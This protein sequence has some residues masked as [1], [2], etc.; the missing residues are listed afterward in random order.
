MNVFFTPLSSY[1]FL[2][3]KLII[4]IVLKFQIAYVNSVSF[5]YSM[6]FSD[7]HKNKSRNYYILYMSQ[8]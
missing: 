3:M 8:G 5:S 4:L 6:Q 7:C 2:Y 1:W